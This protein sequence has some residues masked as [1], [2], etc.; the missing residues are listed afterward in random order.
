VEP[1]EELPDSVFIEDSAVVWKH[2]ALITQM[3]EDREG[4][5][6]VVEAALRQFH[7]ISR[8]TGEG[9]LEGGDVMHIGDTTYVGLSTRTNELGAESL[10][11]FLTPIGRRV[12]TIQVSDCLHLKSG[13][14]YLGNGTLLVVPGW[15]DVSHFDVAKVL[16]TED[17]ESGS[18]NCLRIR[19]YLLIP[20]G[21]PATK[22]LLQR[23][24]E[25][26]ETYMKCLTISEFEKG[27]GSLTCLSLIW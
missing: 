23:F 8:V 27:G 18:A 11:T 2:H 17:G 24:A 14:T 19:D 9:K 22:M 1:N 26:H 21:Y 12:I 25:K 10:K 3:C 5:Q 16:Y 13:A 7:T 6:V 20:A 4:E 15:F